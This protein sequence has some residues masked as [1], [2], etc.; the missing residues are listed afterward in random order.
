MAWEDT[1]EALGVGNLCHLQL[2]LRVPGGAGRGP[3]EASSSRPRR[4]RDGR[5]LAA[6]IETEQLDEFGNPEAPKTSAKRKRPTKKARK[7]AENSDPDGTD[8]TTD[9]SD[10]SSDSEVEEV[11]SNSELADSLPAKT[12]VEKR[13]RKTKPAKKKAKGK[14]REPAQGSIVLAHLPLPSHR[15]LFSSFPFALPPLAYLK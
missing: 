9:D 5:R 8:F 10:S 2:K 4:E 3:S 12:L 14:A 13:R 15:P 7:A 6:A 11:L 1:L